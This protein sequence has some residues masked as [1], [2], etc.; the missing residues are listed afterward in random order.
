M[1]AGSRRTSRTRAPR[2]CPG[3][4]TYRSS[5]R[6]SRSSTPSCR[7][8]PEAT[9]TV[10]SRRDLVRRRGRRGANR[11]R[12]FLRHPTGG[13]RHPGSRATRPLLGGRCAPCPDGTIARGR[14]HPARRRGRRRPARRP[15]VLVLRRRR[16]R[17][18]RRPRDRDVP[19]GQRSDRGPTGAPDG[20]PR[21]D[22]DGGAV[23][24]RPPARGRDGDR[25]VPRVAGRRGVQPVGD[26]ATAPG[27][28][29]TAHAGS[30]RR[31]PPGGPRR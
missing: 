6:S 13:T 20:G 5:T 29:A 28:R 14:G 22:R 1:D 25:A 26:R 17:P 3:T 2:S 10:G 4:G 21:G 11:G 27:G 24:A 16:L 7:D 19:A 12:A 18:V 31:R 23:T 15:V 9:A 30:P 8:E